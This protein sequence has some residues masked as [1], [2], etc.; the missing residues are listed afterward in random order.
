MVTVKARRRFGLLLP[1]ALLA[2]LLVLAWLQ[3]RWTGELS[4]AEAERL[5]SG[6]N[7]SLVRFSGELDFELARIL[8]AFSMRAPSELPEALA[9]FRHQSHYPDIVAELYRLAFDDGTARG[10]ETRGRRSFVPT[11]PPPELARLAERAK[12]LPSS[13][14]DARDLPGLPL[15]LVSSDPLSIVVPSRWAPGGR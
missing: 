3:Y 2:L 13:S 4:R 10:R 7:S 5:K 9:E 8:R 15:A 6:L 11:T 1:L 14:D 12:V